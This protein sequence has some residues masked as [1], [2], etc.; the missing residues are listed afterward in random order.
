M[1][2]LT[3]KQKEEI[4]QLKSK[5]LSSRSIAKKVLGRS[6]R[7]STVT[8]YL[9]T[10]EQY[11]V[12]KDVKI[13]LF[14]LETAPAISYFWGKRY[15]INVGQE[16][17]ISES[18]ILSYSVKWL[19]NENII[20]GSLNYEEVKSEDD[21][22]LCKE[23]FE[24]LNQSDIVIAHNGKNFDVPLLNARLIY[25][26]FNPPLPFRIVDTLLT[27]RRHFRFP[28]NK[29]ND[30]A[31]Y[32]DVGEK[33]DTGG[34]SLWRDYLHGSE[35]ARDNMVAYNIHDVVLLEGVYLK[36][37]AWDSTHPNINN[38]IEENCCPVCGS[39]DFEA[40]GKLYRTNV[41]QYYTYRC[42]KCG[43]IFRNRKRIPETQVLFA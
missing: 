37:R 15:D 20:S 22:R 35:E 43:R 11:E 31:I 12:P 9:K 5:G 13:L 28:S 40:T 6:S 39:E 30:L 8:D 41:S 34:F 7:K 10:K 4:D 25:N 2:K 17:I 38:Y 19:D 27:A 14:D 33:V 26:G 24:L 23:L 36:L 1:A 16:Q 29:L 3:R 21:S 18:F 32:L 42:E